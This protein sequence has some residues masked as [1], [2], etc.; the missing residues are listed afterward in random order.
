MPASKSTDPCKKLACQIQACL[1]ENRYQEAKCQE[2]INLML[3]CCE[4]Y[5]AKSNC[6]D[7]FKDMWKEFPKTNSQ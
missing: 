2:V 5:G 4:K 1:Q 6:C 7:G 3:K